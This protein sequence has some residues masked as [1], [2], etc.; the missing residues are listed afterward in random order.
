[1]KC[2]VKSCIEC[3]AEWH[4]GE[5]CS[6]YQAR[7]KRMPEE[8]EASELEVGKISKKCPGCGIKVMKNGWVPRG[9]GVGCGVVIADLR[10]VGVII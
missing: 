9:S 10:I 4:E 5:T 8:E 7:V 3:A 2:A 1:M 6:E